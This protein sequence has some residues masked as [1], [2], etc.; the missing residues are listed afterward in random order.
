MK[1]D[2]DDVNARVRG[3]GTHLFGP[4]EFERLEHAGDLETLAAMFR[5]RGIAVPEGPEGPRP[6]QLELAVRRW[7]ASFLDTLARWAGPRSAALP[8]VFADL[9][10][11]TIRAMIRGALQRAP[12]PE[13]LAGT[14]PTPA[15]P[16]R[17]LEELARSPT[18]ARVAAHLLAW[19]HPFAAALEP[20]A[21]PSQPDLL[22]IEAALGAAAAREALA[23]AR[24]AGDRDLLRLVTESID[25]DNALTALALAREST[26]LRPRDLFIAGGDRLTIGAFEEAA[27]TREVGAAGRRLAIALGDAPCVECLG[28]DGGSLVGLED[29]LLGCRLRELARAAR[30]DPLRVWTVLRFALMLRQQVA[31]LQRAVWTVTLGAELDHRV[32]VPA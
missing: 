31:A 25:F 22:A 24:R 26:D 30:I 20:V 17:A 3:L 12:A 5:Q 10:R 4:D 1:P 15:L 28:R 19:H 2:W 13:R 21:T 14:I 32:G 18:T 11:R 16:E 7:A 8:F 27:A 9:D 29:D 23:A 6:E